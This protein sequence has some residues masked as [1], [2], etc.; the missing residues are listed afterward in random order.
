MVH[1]TPPP[2]PAI[3]Q[4]TPAIESAQAATHAIACTAITIANARRRRRRTLTDV[5]DADGVV[6]YDDCERFCGRRCWRRREQA[7]TRALTGDDVVG[8]DVCCLW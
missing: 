6:I 5:I 2:P 3:E 1:L 7:R 8:D 4:H